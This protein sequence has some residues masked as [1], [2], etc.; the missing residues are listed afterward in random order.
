M[1]EAELTLLSL[2][3]ESPRYG[4]ELQALIEERGLR[5]WIT[6]GFSSIFYLLN[7]LEKHGLIVGE[8]YSDASGMPRKR[9]TLT[10]AG[11]GVLQTAVADLLRQPHAL[12]SGFELGLANLHILK[13][14][15]VFRVLTHHRSDLRQRY[16]TI[17][18]SY[19][20]HQREAGTA[21]DPISA[22]YTHSLTVMG[23]ELTWLDNFLQEWVQRYPG[24]DRSAEKPATAETKNAHTAATVSIR[25]TSPDVA[26]R[27]QRIR[28]PTDK[29]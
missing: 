17:E 16:A 7:K 28:R 24:A 27:L 11:S 14:A 15:Q 2:L 12:G 29:Q 13:P 25:R 23:A 3:S 5:E 6:I 19:Q 22:L 26:K 1:N 4:H 9:Y 20:R 10:E 21:I 18:Q 8:T